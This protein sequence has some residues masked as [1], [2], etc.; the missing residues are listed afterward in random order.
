LVGTYFDADLNLAM[1][2]GRYVAVIESA[3]GKRANRGGG[4]QARA[5]RICILRRGIAMIP[6][7]RLALSRKPRI[8]G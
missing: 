1:N 8:T 4:R 5:D 3:S 2:A 6:A 7:H